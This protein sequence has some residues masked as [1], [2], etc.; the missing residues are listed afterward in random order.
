MESRKSAAN[1]SSEADKMNCSREALLDI[2]GR[3]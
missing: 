3:N 2:A 1:Q